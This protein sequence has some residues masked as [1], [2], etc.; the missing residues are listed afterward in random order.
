MCK[1]TWRKTGD[2]VACSLQIF[3]HP[4]LMQ[5]VCKGSACIT[6]LF[7]NLGEAVC[8]ALLEQRVIA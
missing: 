7:A 8:L 3:L 6:V 2:I 4:S 5:T 1:L